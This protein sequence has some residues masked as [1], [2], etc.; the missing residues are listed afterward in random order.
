MEI[1]NVQPENTLEI[2]HSFWNSTFEVQSGTSLDPFR[3]WFTELKWSFHNE[4]CLKEIY[5]NLQNPVGGITLWNVDKQC[6]GK[7]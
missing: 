2:T 4:L 1:V 3:D 7:T 6:T 5:F